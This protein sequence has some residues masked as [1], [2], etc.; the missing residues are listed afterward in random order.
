ML[1][2]LAFVSLWRRRWGEGKRGEKE[3]EGKRKKVKKKRKT[4]AKLAHV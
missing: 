2:L 1:Q 3:E 4:N